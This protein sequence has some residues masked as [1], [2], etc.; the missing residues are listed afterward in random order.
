[1]QIVPR[2]NVNELKDSLISYKK[3]YVYGAGKE[4]GKTLELLNNIEI[5]V[6]AIVVS[7]K[8]VAPETVMDIPVIE[9]SNIPVHD[10]N[11]FL[12]GVSELY[13]QEVEKIL[14][15]LR[16]TNIV[17]L[18]NK[19]EVWKLNRPLP[20]LEITAKI[21]CKIGCKFCPQTDLYKAYFK[22]NLHRCKEMSMENYK[23]C[24]GHM[25]RETVITFAGFVEPFLHPYGC[26]MIRYAHEQGH[27]V[28]LYTTFVGLT[29]KQFDTIKEIPF[30]EVVLHTPDKKHYAEIP[31]TEEYVMILDEAL[32]LRKANGEPFIDSA[33]CQSEPSEEFL[34]IARGRIHVES[35]LIDRA[36]LMEDDE[37]KHSAYKYG[38]LVCN[39]SEKQNHWVLLPD[40]TVVLCCMDFGL[41]HQL[42]NLQSS[43]YEAIISG[44]AYQVL[45]Q[46]MG[47]HYQGEDILCRNCTSSSEIKDI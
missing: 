6:D 23:K 21:G 11:V 32:D 38:R 31:I 28:E 44:D 37:L 22:G 30:R 2:K 19:T 35:A 24:I 4:A 15:S 9:I 46:Q 47:C 33:N 27:P 20:K 12:L 7:D 42:G 10:E 43:D 45:R 39:R 8:S 5:K 1:M 25:P 26:E 40:G 29:K 3:I 18:I 34:K 13:C 16:H 36:G 14:I 41:R 17:K